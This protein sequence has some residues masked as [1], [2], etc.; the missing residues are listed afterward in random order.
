MSAMRTHL[1]SHDILA[2]AR[3]YLTSL[4]QTGRLAERLPRQRGRTGA[5][6]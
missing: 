5:A 2:W 1:Q 6:V 4:D 3:A